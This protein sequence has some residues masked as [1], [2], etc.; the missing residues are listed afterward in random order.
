MST[1]S[2][3]SLVE[4]R[5]DLH[6]YPETGWREFRTTALVAEAL[7]DRGFT[8]ALGAD[9]VNPD[10]R[11]GVPD[12][13][14]A[15][16]RRAMEEGAPRSYLDRMGDIT[17][18]VASKR[19]GDGPV[20]GVRVDM[21]AL[22]VTEASDDDHV[23]AQDGFASC[24]PGKMHACG[25]DGHTAI[26]IGVAREIDKSGG[27]DGT[28]KLFFQPAEEG[29]RGG[30]PMSQTDA[31][32]AVEYFVAIHLGLG[33]E[34]GTIIAGR[35]LPLPNTKLD[36]R[37]GGAPS[38]SGH[39]P[40]EGR[41]ALQA[42]ATAISNLY[43]IARHSDGATRINVGEVSSPNPQNVISDDA[44]MR[45]E[46][47]GETPELDSYMTDRAEAIVDA[48]A[49]M[50]KVD[51]TR[52]LYGQTTTFEPDES[53]VRAVS[54][55]A[56]EVPAVKNVISRK[57]FSGSEDASFLIR[58]VQQ[59]G[60]EATYVGIGASNP[61]GHHTARF[62]IDERALKIGVDLVVET[63]RTL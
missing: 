17:G 20:V 37:Y 7:E 5:R 18:L 29:G 27:F 3:L 11:L 59:T 31:L 42:M 30:K 63:I 45:V 41:N 33:L 15:S 21:D 16:K 25:H 51:V 1:I 9:A 53:M 35:E 6:K 8:V 60:G 23:P 40:N 46:V 48:A 44:R 58:K 55:A 36:V 56:A 28:V 49:E 50:H 12:D 38:H 47:R 43:G 32:D 26:G 2:D 57:P 22:K 24:H 52:E 34:T 19:Y 13:L 39:A 62:D 14:E 61:S 10:G 4:L 54:T